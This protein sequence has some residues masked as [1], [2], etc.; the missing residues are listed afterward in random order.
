[1]EGSLPQWR[2]WVPVGGAR[3]TVEALG[4]SGT[5]A[6]F[7]VD[8]DAVLREV[9]R[10]NM[11]MLVSANFHSALPD[12]P[13]IQDWG[14]HVVRQTA[15]LAVLALAVGCT[16]GASGATPEAGGRAPSVV[17]VPVVPSAPAGAVDLPLS[18]RMA[19]PQDTGTF[20]EAWSAVAPDAA[21]AS[22]VV[23]WNDVPATA[24]RRVDTAFVH[25]EGS[26]VVIDLLRAQDKQSTDCAFD[27]L[28]ACTATVALDAPLGTRTL[29]RRGF[30][31]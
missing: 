19:A 20:G 26:S 25:V 12:V 31:S 22:V 29:S 3:V 8:V 4:L 15:L 23:T 17:A 27:G 7:G 24:C 21:V 11:T 14:A 13:Q 30:V 28:V 6:T 5:A 9:H 2:L 1:M 16:S 18:V 10:S